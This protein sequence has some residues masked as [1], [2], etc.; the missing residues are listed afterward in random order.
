MSA[1][2]L[3]L[4]SQDRPLD[5]FQ[6][7]A[8][9]VGDVRVLSGVAID[10]TDIVRCL[11]LDVRQQL[12][13][14]R[15]NTSLTAR[16]QLLNIACWIDMDLHFVKFFCARAVAVLLNCR[17]SKILLKIQQSAWL[18]RSSFVRNHQSLAVFASKRDRELN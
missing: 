7:T 13:A 9:L 4:L 2:L 11:I 6:I 16:F 18:C 10:S 14:V 15:L 1:E 8:A 3:V 5:R 17:D 12:E